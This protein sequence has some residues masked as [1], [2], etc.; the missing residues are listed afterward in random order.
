MNNYNSVILGC[1]D[2]H[3]LVPVSDK[4]IRQH[5]EEGKLINYILHHRVEKDSSTTTPLRLVANS[6]T[7]NF[8]TGLAVNDF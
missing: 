3:T 1:I 5:K 7:K 4:E 8:N 6:A 2:R